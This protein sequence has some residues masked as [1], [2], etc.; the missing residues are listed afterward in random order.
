M[1]V[2]REVKPSRQTVRNERY[3]VLGGVVPMKD[4]RRASGR[5]SA[6]PLESAI[7]PCLREQASPE[8]KEGSA[9]VQSGQNGSKSYVYFT[10]AS[11][12]VSIRV[13]EEFGSL[14]G[15][16]EWRGSCQCRVMG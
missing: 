7:S 14:C 10:H 5:I 15:T 9:S 12:C 1:C 11:I 16:P 6:V 4:K 3:V 13:S 2:R 8:E